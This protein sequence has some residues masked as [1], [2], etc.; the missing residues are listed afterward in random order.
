MNPGLLPPGTGP[1]SVLMNF[2]YSAPY[3]TDPS[4]N[5]PDRFLHFEVYVQ[6]ACCGP[7]AGAG[8]A[9]LG[10]KEGL[11]VRA[12]G[13]GAYFF[14]HVRF[15]W[16]QDRV[17]YVA[18]LHE[19][20]AGT[21]AL[22]GALVSGLKPLG[23]ASD[24]SKTTTPSNGSETVPLPGMT[25]PVGV[26]T[27]GGAVWV[28]SI[29]DATSAFDAAEWP[30][31]QTGPGIQRFDARTAQP[32]GEPIRLGRK[33]LLTLGLVPRVDWRPSG[34]AS[35][36]GRV[37]TIV[38][39]PESATLYGL[40]AKTGQTTAKFEMPFPVSSGGDVTGLAAAYGSLWVTLYGPTE[41]AHRGEFGGIFAPGAVWRVDPNTGRVLARTVVGAGAVHVAVGSDAVWVANYRDDTISRIDPSTN[42][43]EATIPVGSGPSAISTAPDGVWVANSLDG[44]VSRI[45]PKTDRVVARI[46]VGE[47]PM[48][49]TASVDRV[50]VTS[51]MS[52]T[53]STIDPDSDRVI[54]THRTGRGP[55]GVAEY[56]GRVWILNDLDSTL[57]SDVASV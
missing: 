39:S 54:D 14:N 46:P 45:D 10:G 31:H 7:P 21:T 57:T 20:G 24:A 42:R 4:K 55:I 48:G 3:E 23:R 9:V 51:Y 27:A 19:F 33:E 49:L 16:N 13:P 5:G 40:D 12:G 6:G 41:P 29:G 38:S 18:S 32:V 47:N 56:A 15:F 50:R 34:L 30:D 22:L 1:G 52:D 11:L 2:T 36:F 25:G 44:T 35:G 37:W 53:V 8:R 28:A 43:L 26:A 17:D